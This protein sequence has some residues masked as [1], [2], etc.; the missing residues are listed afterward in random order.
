MLIDKRK[1][2]TRAVHLTKG[3]FEALFQEIQSL[4]MSKTPVA[5]SFAPGVENRSRLYVFT[6]S[7]ELCFV[8]AHAT[9][10]NV[11]HGPS[12]HLCQR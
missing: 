1:G 4:P 6:A 9:K 2:H 11:W 3:D 7:D 12:K 10:P 8:E 5:M